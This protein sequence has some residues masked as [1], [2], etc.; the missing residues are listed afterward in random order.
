MPPPYH[1]RP[2]PKT[3]TPDGPAQP[4]RL[5]GLSVVLPAHNEVQS[6]GN[7]VQDALRVGARCAERVEVLIVDDGSRDGTGALALR[8]AESHPDVRVL[9]HEHNRGY[10]AALRTGFMSA[11]H[12]HIFY[13]DADGQFDLEDLPSLLELLSEYEVVTGYRQH[14]R[15]G[16][17][18]SLFGATFT[19]AT[20]HLLGVCVRDVNCAF[21]V[22]PRALFDGLTLHS[23]GALIDAEM[24]AAARRAELR[25]GELPVTHRARLAG[26]QS[27]ARWDVIGQALVEMALVWA[28]GRAPATRVAHAP[29][30]HAVDP[31]DPHGTRGSGPALAPR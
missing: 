28:R 4:P 19:A 3:R 11:R 18:R 6:L 30:M 25:I 20:N 1:P 31:L 23:R 15:D 9:T 26:V 22:Y 16:R 13:T 27:G 29:S 14:R 2:V 7:V 12:D 5:G 17:L 21:K 8:L 10:G 24:L